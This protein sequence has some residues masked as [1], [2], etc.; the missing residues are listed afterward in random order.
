MPFGK[1][2]SELE[3]GRNSLAADGQGR[4]DVA[5]LLPMVVAR[6]WVNGFELGCS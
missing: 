6:G 3:P 5:E 2:C 1:L 4:V